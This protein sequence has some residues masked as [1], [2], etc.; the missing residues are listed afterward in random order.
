MIDDT[1]TPTAACRPPSLDDVRATFA[2]AIRRFKLRYFT[3]EELAE[4]L[5]TSP[6]F[7]ELWA[8]AHREAS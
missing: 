5:I 2:L 8:A 6:C 3:P 1:P 7:Q 4:A